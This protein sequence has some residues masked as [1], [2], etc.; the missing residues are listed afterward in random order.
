MYDFVVPAMPWALHAAA[1]LAVA[2]PAVGDSALADLAFPSGPSVMA[3]IACHGHYWLEVAKRPWS[4]PRQWYLGVGAHRDS[5]RNTLGLSSTMGVG[6]RW[7]LVPAP[8]KAGNSF[9]LEAV[10][11]GAASEAR[12][13]SLVAC[14]MSKVKLR[15]FR[16]E[17][18]AWT[19]RGTKRVGADGLP[20]NW[21]LQAGDCG[22]EVFLGAL[23]QSC[24]GRPLE[25]GAG[26]LKSPWV[27]A[28]APMGSEVAFERHNGTWCGRLN[29]LTGSPKALADCMEE[30]ARSVHCTAF[31][32]GVGGPAQG[33]CKLWW[34]DFPRRSPAF[35]GARHGGQQLLQQDALA[36]TLGDLDCRQHDHADLYLARRAQDPTWLHSC[37]ASADQEPVYWQESAL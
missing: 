15:A 12:F 25:V 18:T 16:D 2:G 33:L 1:L 24:A 3:R 8:G 11:L 7:R 36:Q 21:W 28:Q 10:G 4:C 19:L 32:H 29:L 14:S 26:P 13:L 34:K 6:Q 22:N 17:P 35:A 27:L 30:C 23:G 20:A 5:S 37:L 31:G 9:L